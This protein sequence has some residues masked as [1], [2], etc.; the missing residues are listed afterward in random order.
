[1]LTLI[2]TVTLGLGFALFA[3]Q[4]TQE[5]TLNFGKYYLPNIPIYVVVLGTL[6]I[7]L[8]AAFIAYFGNHLSSQLTISEQTD[9]LKKLKEENAEVVKRAHKLEL[10]NTKLKTKLGEEIDGDSL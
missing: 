3:T 1:M 4:N 7:G 6:F 5:V 8:L 9:E 2:V 10:E